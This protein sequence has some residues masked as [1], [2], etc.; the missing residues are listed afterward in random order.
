MDGMG[1][2]RTLLKTPIHVASGTVPDAL[3]P[4]HTTEKNSRVRTN[5]P[6]YSMTRGRN[7][8][9]AQEHHST[10]LIVNHKM[11]MLKD[12]VT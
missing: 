2:R 1:C 11:T 4:P 7:S 12:K 5:P 10:D 9:A 3:V 8:T 6:K